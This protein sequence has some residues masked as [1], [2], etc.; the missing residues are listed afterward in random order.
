MIHLMRYAEY[1]FTYYRL[2]AAG[3]DA[4]T[5]V[6]AEFRVWNRSPSLTSRPRLQLPSPGSGRD[7][8]MPSSGNPGKTFERGVCVDS[9]CTNWPGSGRGVVPASIARWVVSAV[10]RLRRS[11]T[12][13]RKIQTGTPGAAELLR[14]C[15]QRQDEPP[16]SAA[17]SGHS[18]GPENQHT[19][20]YALNG[21]VQPLAVASYTSTWPRM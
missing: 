21:A 6:V 4:Q 2:S 8:W 3:T 12:Q 11:R 18:C 7:G 5:S 19:V 10:N 1:S 16:Q 13:D 20:R 15:G 14:H 9:V 17:D